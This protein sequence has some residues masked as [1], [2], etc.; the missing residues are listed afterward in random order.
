MSDWVRRAQVYSPSHAQWQFFALSLGTSTLFFLY[1]L[2]WNRLLAAV[3]CFLLR[4]TTWAKHEPGSF[5]IEA[6]SAHIS[7]I[8][9][10]LVLRDLRYYSANQT[11]R[12]VKCYITWRYWFWR[13]RE[14]DDIS[15]SEVEE[16]KSNVSA[17]P[18][19]ILLSF[20]GLEWLL[21]NRTMVF[22]E[23]LK[24][25]TASAS[26]EA[27]YSQSSMGN[28]RSG[29][30]PETRAS[31]L[32]ASTNANGQ[33]KSINEQRYPP[34]GFRI[35]LPRMDIPSKLWAWILTK[36]P[37]VELNDLL[38]IALEATH[39]AIMLG[40]AST[41]SLFTVTFKS[42]KGTY[43]LRPAKSRFDEYRQSYQLRFQQVLLTAEDNPDY[44]TSM[45]ETGRQVHE[46]FR[47]AKP[48]GT[49]GLGFSSFRASL[50]WV[51]T[52][53]I[54]IYET[55]E[56]HKPA[57]WVG[58]QAFMTEA[59]KE[60]AKKDEEEE[61]RR[62]SERKKLEVGPE[63]AIERRLVQTDRL[64]LLYYADVAG[65]V[66]E[67]PVPMEGT[68]E[69]VDVGNGD[70]APGWGIDLVVHGG[71]LSYGPWADRQRAHLQK[72]LSPPTWSVASPF[73]KLK[74]GDPRL[75]TQFK[76]HVEFAEEV[77]LRLPCRE[78]SK[79]WQFDGLPDMGIHRRQAAQLG[80]KA[81]RNSTIHY[82]MPMVASVA[83][84]Q[85]TVRIELLN[86]IADSSLNNE[87][88]LEAESCYIRC[89]LPSP[90]RWDEARTWEFL[91]SLHKPV[92]YILRDHITL[93]TD[94][95]KDWSA[96]PPTAL[97]QFI[98]MLYVVRLNLKEYAISLPVNDQN[99]VDSLK[100]QDANVTFRLEGSGLNSVVNIPSLKYRPE[101]TTIPFSIESTD[102]L[103]LNL[104]LPL[105]NTRSAHSTRQIT[106][107]G[108]VSNLRIDGAYR[109]HASV[110]PDYV[111][112][113]TL[114]VFGRSCSYKAFGWSIRHFISLQGNYFGSFTNFV[115][116]PE[117]N[118]KR[119]KG[120]TLGDP[121]DE[122]YREGQANAFEVSLETRVSDVTIALPEALLGYEARD[123]TDSAG[124]GSC[125]LLAIPDISLSFRLHDYGM[126]M[127]LNVHPISVSFA[128]HYSDKQFWK[129]A[130][131]RRSRKEVLNISE[132]D[133]VANRLFGPK[134]HAA[135]YVCMWEIIIGD[136]QGVLSP[137]QVGKLMTVLHTFGV[138]FKDEANAPAQEFLP[139]TYPDVTFLKLRLE[140]LSVNVETESVAVIFSL[141]QGSQLSLND[142]P[143]QT[144]G[145]MISVI[146]AACEVK[147][148]LKGSMDGQTWLEAG[149]TSLDVAIDVYSRPFDW[150][151]KADR[152]LDFIKTQ[153]ASTRRVQ[154]IYGEGPIQG[155]L[156]YSQHGSIWLPHPCFLKPPAQPVQEVRTPRKHASSDSD[157]E[158]SADVDVD[159][160]LALSR[161]PSYP[162]LMRSLQES[163][164]ADD[165]DERTSHTGSMPDTRIETRIEDEWDDEIGWPYLSHHANVVRQYRNPYRQVLEQEMHTSQFELS[166]DV[167]SSEPIGPVK[168]RTKEENKAKIQTN[169]TFNHPRDDDGAVTVIQV[170]SKAGFELTLSPMIVHVVRDLLPA[171]YGASSSI[172][173]EIDSL[174]GNLFTNDGD[175]RSNSP[176]LEINIPV[177]RL[178]T[179]QSILS[180]QEAELL[181]EPFGDI[182]SVGVD[183][184]K[185]IISVVDIRI[186][187]PSTSGIL[188]SEERPLM[189]RAQQALLTLS[190]YDSH[191]L[192]DMRH[193][194]A[195]THRALELTIEDSHATLGSSIVSTLGNVDITL[196]SE[197][198]AYVLSTISVAERIFSETSSIVSNWTRL[199]SARSQYTAWAVLHNTSTAESDPLSRVVTS[200][201][202]QSGRPSVLRGDIN[203]RILNHARQR[204]P[205]LPSDVRNTIIE[206]NKAE[207]SAIPAV[208][209]DDLLST[210]RETWSDWIGELADEEVEQLPL[211][212]LINPLSSSRPP[213]D[214]MQP[215]SIET[216][217]LQLVL[218]DT[219]EGNS[220]IR[221]GPFNFK[222]AE[223]RPTLAIHQTALSAVSVTRPSNA[224]IVQSL[225][226]VGVVCDLGTFF[227]DLSPSLL[228]FTG[229]LLRTRQHLSAPIRSPTSPTFGKQFT[230]PAPTAPKAS[231]QVVIDMSFH[232]EKL[233]ILSRAYNFAFEISL[234]NPTLALH[235]L[236]RT[237]QLNPRPLLQLAPDSAASISCAWE[238]LQ[239]RVSERVASQEQSVLA[240]FAV[241]QVYATAV[242]Y[243]RSRERPAVR[244]S[245]VIGK[246]YFSVPRHVAR[247]IQSVETWWDDYFRNQVNP[248]LRLFSTA[249]SPRPARR[250][251]FKPQG[252]LGIEFQSNVT[253]AEIRLHAVLGVWLVWQVK[254]SG[255]VLEGTKSTASAIPHGKAVLRV[256]SQALALETWQ[257]PHDASTI[258]KE[259]SF[260][261]P[262]PPM[263]V[264]VLLAN[265]TLRCR[266]TFELFEVV[267]NAN[268]IDAFVRASRQLASSDIERIFSIVRRPGESAP[269]SQSS[270]PSP[271]RSSLEDI[272][273]EAQFILSGLRLVLEGESSLC[274]LDIGNVLGEGS[275][276]NTWGFR[277]SDISFSL[278]PKHAGS[279]LDFDRRSR[280]AYMVFDMKVLSFLDKNLTNVLDVQ[281][282]KVHAVLQAAALVVLGDLVDSYQAEVMRGRE[283]VARQRLMRRQ[284]NRSSVSHPTRPQRVAATSTWLDKRILKMSISSIGAAIPLVLHHT[285]FLPSESSSV[286]AFLLSISSVQFG[287]QFGQNGD[288]SVKCFALQFLDQFDQSIPAHFNS[289]SHRSKN[290]MVYP[291]MRAEVSS[292]QTVTSQ[293]W[294]IHSRVSGFE[295]DLDPEI[296]TFTFSL[297]DVYRLG[298]SK[299]ESLAE[300]VQ[301]P[302]TSM[303][304]RNDKPQSRTSI[305]TRT[306]HVLA[307]LEFQSGRV[308]LHHE[309]RQASRRRSAPRLSIPGNQYSSEI[310]V[311]ILLP[312][313]SLWTEWRATPASLKGGSISDEAPSS[314]SFKSTIHSSKN[315]VPPTVLQF[316]SQLLAKVEARLNRPNLSAPV[317]VQRPPEET[318]DPDDDT[319]K[320]LQTMSI[321]FSL[322]IDQST[323]EFTCQPDVNVKG[324]LQWESGGFVATASPGAKSIAF[325]GS[326]ENLTAHLRHGYLN[327]DCFSASIRD[328]AFS[329][330]F[331]TSRDAAGIGSTRTSI[332]VE[333][334]LK[335]TALFARLQDILCFKAV[336]FDSIPTLGGQGIT[337][338]SPLTA[339]SRESAFSVRKLSKRSWKTVLLLRVRKMDA[340]L[341]LGPAVSTL[342]LSLEPVV[343]R[344]LLSNQ[345]SELFLS[346]GLL[347]ITASGLFSGSLNVPDFHFRTVRGR[348]GNYERKHGKETLLNIELMSGFLK[349]LVMYE[350]KPVFLYDS[351]PLRVV[352][353][354]DWSKCHVAHS[355]EH[356]LQLHFNL[357]ASGVNIV[358]VTTAPAVLV[359]MIQRIQSL[360]HAQYEGA[361]KESEAFR[362]TNGPKR[363][364][365]EVATSMVHRSDKTTE[366]DFAWM[367]V[368]RMRVKLDALFIGIARESLSDGQA[369]GGMAATSFDACLTRHVRGT[370][371]ASQSEMVMSL[372]SLELHRYASRATEEILTATEWLGRQHF[373]KKEVLK[374]P[375]MMVEM[376]TREFIENG[377]PVLAFDLQNEQGI[378]SSNRQFSIGTDLVLFDWVRDMY[379]LT[380]QHVTEMRNRRGS[381]TS[382]ESKEP[383]PA[384]AE[385]LPQAFSLEPSAKSAAVQ[386]RS[387]PFERG[388]KQWRPESIKMVPPV[389]QQLGNFSP[390]VGFYNLVVQGSLDSAVAIWVHELVTTP[391][392]ELNNVLLSLYTK[393]LQMDMALPK[394]EEQ[395]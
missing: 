15:Y 67:N 126:E 224:A 238:R 372:G 310:S 125:A 226:H 314:L 153:D 120:I 28:E 268:A 245:L 329:T 32:P 357:V 387:G 202:V 189:V 173:L 146:V 91:V 346:I 169:V 355:D 6:E 273:I 156:K 57:E 218:K 61:A 369:W 111:D 311:D 272:R 246:V 266:G 2:Y 42:G 49:L 87:S 99:I 170:A 150:R 13:V 12:A 244:V 233:S 258:L 17:I 109:Y 80:L 210:L 74:P 19:R 286:P 162:D 154:F 223:R 261:F 70:I 195:G 287:T 265:N 75:C 276:M 208:S 308:R 288:V 31:G 327:E 363:H 282:D 137:K 25:A 204:L 45:V 51:T 123:E 200:P 168:F 333:T 59:E 324:S 69:I 160:Q 304:V 249:S 113:L 183:M 110:K 186:L 185:R 206:M 295:L 394:D 330:A 319:S 203:W 147:S 26:D 301:S 332:V 207:L 253:D 336:W 39:G 298:L 343:F 134:P 140:S 9:G 312:V 167:R 316:V 106:E 232:F 124:L 373:E 149:T 359:D 248:L 250:V 43:S 34:L 318:L 361:A 340:Q 100:D 299:L 209:R 40:N 136:V 313:V 114:N 241:N 390:G 98:P 274:L 66:P 267:L 338:T 221:I 385:Q 269:V 174:M 256:T 341:D 115:L 225:R 289:N 82:T 219:K 337:P 383:A 139:E 122:K 14:N 117:A 344:T 44:Q 275:G 50:R 358:A 182:R 376:R 262:F 303:Q 391:V 293:E 101:A 151:R 60:Q 198:P 392:S 33:P 255:I 382:M 285:T 88:F 103:R 362:R 386:P 164:D 95:G 235:F 22:D 93:F 395:D 335:V 97:P 130:E 354:D 127:T 129:G 72:A 306:T 393:Q 193:E 180:L 171:L 161:P 349:M 84:Y 264:S 270:F 290:Q 213:A 254:N 315:T 76:L 78:A 370:S 353:L 281:V 259:H 365:N 56:E 212:K 166:K 237:G 294:I 36:L 37:R 375:A 339:A 240:E 58:L 85:T 11:I 71:T 321:S 73:K 367:T 148:L 65:K 119:Q 216:G 227:V 194:I 29:W 247:L 196:Q 105:W 205:H 184:D 81:A 317:I 199:D 214:I 116:S 177:I 280:L 231:T 239:L 90:L 374:V 229:R 222:V 347:D 63:Y 143:T 4:F 220:E 62:I 102:E 132:L 179:V 38:P 322:R 53:L 271:T 133:I 48:T 328:L 252:G 108:H 351:Q 325:I 152:Q 138:N 242:W 296:A 18:C 35:G 8:S 307:S 251:S 7:L 144:A 54:G 5:W 118:L 283:E 215:L 197:A 30:S 279:I 284:R 142:L 350:R 27:G 96:G 46:T 217:F 291:E 83:G 297:L 10:R 175:G 379:H 243:S 190:T 163:S 360:L 158:D 121:I 366:A 192:A 388:G 201:L 68:E 342:R 331:S 131:D 52:S 86:V 128:D 157:S 187:N 368:Q 309:G 165:S 230:L 24:Q 323:L 305:S 345:L 228:P 155:H 141:P 278:A 260:I 380:V 112:R 104:T 92:A 41:P 172:E 79:D 159:E 135:T 16:P 292:K 348:E 381:K 176:S 384:K 377:V 55:K 371:D 389:I 257:D 320:S 47:K 145:G 77:Q 1:F 277:V 23:I 300:V 94:L 326:V 89:N 334:D 191:I 211:F 352:T 107:I 263:Q 21:Y 356:K 364:V 20:E 178:K 302:D 234:V 236:S 181:R 3:I 188:G 378:Q 64:D